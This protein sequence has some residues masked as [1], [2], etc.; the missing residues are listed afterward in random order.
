MIDPL[1]TSDI[2]PI[3]RMKSIHYDNQ[4]YLIKN[5]YTIIA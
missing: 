2:Y 4:D 5:D 1:L 3:E